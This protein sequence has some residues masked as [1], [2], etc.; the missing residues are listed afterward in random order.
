MF[1]VPIFR[2]TGWSLALALC[3]GAGFDLSEASHAITGGFK[4]KV[5]DKKA[6]TFS[7]DVAPILYKN[8]AGCHHSGDIAPFSLVNYQDAKKHARMLAAVTKTRYMPPWHADSHG[9][10]VGEHR[11]TDAQIETLRSWADAGAPAGDPKAMPAVPHFENGWRLGK[12]DLVFQPAKAYTLGAEGSDVYR[13]FVIP[14]DTPENRYLSAIEVHP[15]NR[16]VVHHVIAYLDTSGQAR[17]LEAKSNDGQPGY[18]SFGGV[19][20]PA[21]G[22]LGGWVPGRE[23]ALL[24]SNVGILMPKHADIVLQVHYHRDG[25]IEADKTSIGLYYARGT[26]DKQQRT[27]WTGNTGLD[28]P[29]GE[30]RYTA[31]GNDLPVSEDITV[32]DVTPHMHLVGHDMKV[33][34]TLPDKTEHQMISVPQWDFNWQNVYVYKQP[35][36]LPKGSVIH[37]VAHYDNSPDNPRNPSSP[38]KRV[39]YGEETTDEM[40][41]AFFNY[42]VD[43][44]H[45]TKGVKAQENEAL[46]GVVEFIMSRFD[47]NKDGKLDA[48]E[49]QA[50]IEMQKQ[51]RPDSAGSAFAKG[52]PAT[53]AKQALL[54][55]DKDHDGTLDASELV[56]LIKFMAAM[57]GTGAKSS[58]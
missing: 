52:E 8:C 11:L 34:V 57:R 10:F 51:M 18:T 14:T 1:R 16:T 49:I 6:P 21:A 41:F 23:E 12:P 47:K 28:I 44:E 58:R 35:L 37:M 25:K 27:C 38:P 56:S 40:C 43:A 19:G 7:A 30:G 26:I 32:R 39:T 55:F 3:V 45:L 31:K 36:A 50:L 20:F 22:A 4:P 13:C 42:T 5:H 24:P 2:A 46:Y 9:E 15:G 17:K 48:S 54:F 29:A 53:Q 33:W